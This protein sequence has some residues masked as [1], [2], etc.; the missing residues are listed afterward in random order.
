ML[1]VLRLR[2]IPPLCYM[3][4]PISL[5]KLIDIFELLRLR[6]HPNHTS[7]RAFDQVSI[8]VPWRRKRCFREPCVPARGLPL[9]V[10]ESVA[11]Y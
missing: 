1:D 10:L 5:F 9:Y 4:V 3:H 11:R 2:N 7:S 6:G 8:G